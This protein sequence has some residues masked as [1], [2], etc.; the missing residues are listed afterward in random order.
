MASTLCHFT[1]AGVYYSYLIINQCVC[2]DS[3]RSEILNRCFVEG[4]LVLAAIVQR[5]YVLP[6]IVHLTYVQPPLPVVPL[7]WKT[8]NRGTSGCLAQYFYS[9]NGRIQW[10]NSIPCFS[11][12]WVVHLTYA[13]RCAKRVDACQHTCPHTNLYQWLHS[14]CLSFGGCTMYVFPNVFLVNQV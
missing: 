2:Y 8:W 5:T 3:P 12:Q 6:P 10:V 11:I 7:S 9:T 14:L 4:D 1:L 13:R